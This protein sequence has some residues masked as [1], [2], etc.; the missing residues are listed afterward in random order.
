I[1]C[2]L[3]SLAAPRGDIW[4]CAAWMLLG[5]GLLYFYYGTVYATIQDIIEPALR[6]VAMAVYFCGQYLLGAALG[7]VGTG[8]ISDYFARRAAATDGSATVTPLHLALGLH[9]AM[10]VVPVLD[11]ILVLI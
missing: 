8:Y 10:Y 1:P 3:M 5:Y 7:P 4:P 9:N 6:G 2:I 11:G